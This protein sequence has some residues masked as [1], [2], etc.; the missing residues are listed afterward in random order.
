LSFEKQIIIVVMETA[1]QVLAP[2]HIHPNTFT[3]LPASDKLNNSERFKRHL[4]EMASIVEKLLA[5][6]KLFYSTSPYFLKDLEHNLPFVHAEFPED[7][8]GEIAFY[9]ICKQLKHFDLSQFFSEMIQRWVLPRGDAEI[10]SSRQLTFH[11]SDFPKK[12]FFVA[13]ILCQVSDEATRSSIREKLPAL[14]QEIAL[15]AVSAH[16]ARHIMATKGLTAEQKTT[17]IHKTIIELSNRKLKTIAADVFVEMHY[18]LLAS[19][20]E[21]KKLREVRHMCRVICYNN[22]FRRLLRQD[23]RQEGNKERKIRFN[24]ALLLV[25]RKYSALS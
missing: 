13:E 12:N 24:C 6:K 17:Q 4:K 8:P 11:F 18:F 22:W 16:H 9:L 7:A 3:I 23:A 25:R 15:G 1:Y 5:V 10:V 14:F 19:D 21:F 2:Q 20:D